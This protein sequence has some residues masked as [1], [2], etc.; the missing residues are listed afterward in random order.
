VIVLVDTSVWAEYFRKRPRLSGGE[1][2]RLDGLIRDDLVATVHPVRAALLSGRVK[3]EHEARVRAALGAMRS[4]DLDWNAAETW[5]AIARCA[6]DARDAGAPSV[7]LVDRMVLLSAERARATLWTLD[8]PLRRL[9]ASR[10][11]TV[12]AD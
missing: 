10:G 1:L 2:D 5:D 6:Q 8:Q 11:S 9:A 7:G 12:L 4:L 3:K